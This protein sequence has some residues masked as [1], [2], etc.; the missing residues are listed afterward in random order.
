M[1]CARKEEGIIAPEADRMEAVRK[2]I[3]LPESLS[4]FALIP[5]GYPG[6]EEEQ[7]DRYEESRVHYMQ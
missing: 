6:E 2:V 3:D 1:A 5:C 7:E 4:A